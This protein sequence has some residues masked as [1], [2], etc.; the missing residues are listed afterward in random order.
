MAAF[1]EEVGFDFAGQYLWQRWP[2]MIGGGDPALLHLVESMNVYW[3]ATYSLLIVA[4]YVP[5]AWS[6]HQRAVAILDRDPGL[7]GGAQPEAVLGRHGLSRAA[8]HR[9]PQVAA[10]LAPV[11]AGP[12][13]AILSGLAQDAGP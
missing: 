3:G 12:F 10:M 9:V 11:V 4:F 7:T 1:S 5:P 6:M 2:V 13:G 8:L